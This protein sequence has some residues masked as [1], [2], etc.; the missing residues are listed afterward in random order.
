MKKEDF[1]RKGTL[2]L[3]KN[4]VETLTQLGTRMESPTSLML[5]PYIC[6]CCNEAL[7]YMEYNL[8]AEYLTSSPISYTEVRNKLKLFSNRYGKSIKQIKLVDSRQDNE[9]KA[10]LRFKWMENWKIHYNLGIYSTPQGHVVGNTQYIA[11]LLQNP[12][13][14]L[15]EDS[16]TLYEFGFFLGS[17]LQRISQ[18]LN[19]LQLDSKINMNEV[20]MDWHYK[21]FHTDKKFNL[22]LEMEDGKELT[23]FLLHLL[24]TV[25]FVGYELPRF[26]S[27]ENPWLLRIQYITAHYVNE[28]LNRIKN[29]DLPHKALISEEVKDNSLLNSTFR[30]CMFH[31]GFYNKGECSIKD[32]YLHEELFFGLIESC[33]EGKSYEEYQKL[34]V[35]KIFS[36]SKTMET[37]LPLPVHCFKPLSGK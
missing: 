3:I 24:S 27:N 28:S 17:V 4:D 29:M 31:Y 20:L 2:L 22:F 16:N 32:E 33:F 18:D 5:L 34:L 15:N 1:I 19:F 26:V 12:L 23:L 37:I 9:F 30:S 8:I 21:D 6:L 14:N 11:F 10:K 13:F 35:R 36:L 25:N 7:N